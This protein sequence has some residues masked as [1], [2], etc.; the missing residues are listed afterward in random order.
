M[1]PAAPPTCTPPSSVIGDN[2]REELRLLS[3]R[4]ARLENGRQSWLEEWREI[5]R[6]ISPKLGRFVV[7]TNETSRGR[8]EDK[9]R[10]IID[11]TATRSLRRF[12]A[13]MMGG[14]SSPARPW[15]R[16][17]LPDKKS[18]DNEEA[19]AWLDEV[20]S[21]VQRVLAQSNFYRTLAGLYE[22][23]GA[24][25]TAAMVVQEDY[26]D[27][28]RYLPLTAGEYCIA[29]DDRLDPASLFRR[30]TMTAEQ[31]VDRFGDAAR[32][33]PQVAALLASNSV[34]QELI[35][36][37]AM[38]RNPK[39]KAGERG[40]MGMAYRSIYWLWAT[41]AIVLEDRPVAEKPFCAARW[42]VVS[43]DA[44]G[45][46]P[47]GDALGDIKQLQS[48][49]LKK[50][51]AILKRVDPPMLADIALKNQA[52]NLTPGGITFV[53]NASGMGMKTAYEVNLPINE[54]TDDIKE[55]QGR[56]QQ[57][58][59]E[60]LWMGISQLDT[61]RT[62]TEI[63]ERKE[64]KMLMLGPALERIHDELLGP[65]IRR[66]M[67]IM[68]RAHL[69]PPMPQSIQGH[70]FHIEYISIMAQAQKAVATTAI[71]RTV[72]F[73]GS[74]AGVNPQI[75]D[76]IDADEALDEYATLLGA[77][78]RIIV[79][80]EQVA[81]IRAARAKQQQQQQQ[82]ANALA[83]VQGAKTLSET[84]AGG[85]QNALQRMTGFG[86]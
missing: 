82:Q 85:G 27:V 11:P 1:A 28:V 18:S 15:F 54:L 70:N 74:L 5:S 79:P 75:M 42:D 17:T 83:A 9:K 51:Q 76:K 81:A 24:F 8:G 16:L 62:A 40:A 4:M 80:S 49:Q 2:A 58:F 72:A 67:A 3:Q 31:L 34:D 12:G 13:G 30:F 69:F 71:E 73:A 45:T 50:A 65:A 6:L 7:A 68:D 33:H 26:E 39:Q 46:G 22:E 43:N 20:A 84:D 59:F 78:S 37:H 35:V 86:A 64:E 29:N 55:I 66:T 21:R 10:A 41:N 77:P 44:Y 23:I 63:A 36:A 19:R 14:M 48:E 47:G 53:P 32:T 57:T 38:I 61:V 25:G 56:I 52:R 60:D